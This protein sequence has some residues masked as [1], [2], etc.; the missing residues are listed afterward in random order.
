MKALRV[1][2]RQSFFTHSVLQLVF[3]AVFS[4]SQL[5][6]QV[7][8]LSMRKFQQRHLGLF[9]QTRQTQRHL[10][11]QNNQEDILRLYLDSTE[12]TLKQAHTYAGTYMLVLEHTYVER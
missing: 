9:V 12:D 7:S 3:T 1:F 5:A 10:C 11:L 4:Y 2:L 8:S 6:A